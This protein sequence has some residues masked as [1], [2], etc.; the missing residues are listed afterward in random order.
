MEAPTRSTSISIS[1]S[2]SCIDS[3]SLGER[4]RSEVVVLPPEPHLPAKLLRT[5][6]P[7]FL[8]VYTPHHTSCPLR[9]LDI[10]QDST[11]SFSRNLI[12]TSSFF[13]CCR[14][15]QVEKYL[16][17]KIVLD[18]NCRHGKPRSGAQDIIGFHAVSQHSSE[19]RSNYP[20]RGR[21]CLV[22]QALH[23]SL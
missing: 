9:V 10:L 17:Q 7:W 11:I 16:D 20:N 6:P 2:I 19:S 15:R 8:S 1:I 14:L 22:G 13:F 5:M 12:L 23:L 21:T 3:T 18:A 4:W